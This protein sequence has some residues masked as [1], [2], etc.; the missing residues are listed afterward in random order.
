MILTDQVF[1]GIDPTSGHKSF[2]YAVL[3]RD[4]TLVAQAD[5][6]MEEV[7][8]LLSERKHAIV[9]VNAPSGVNLGLVREK[10][11]RELREPR[12]LRGVDLRLAEFELRELGVAVSGTPSRAELC[13]SW[14][15]LGFELYRELEKIGF[16]RYPA[17]EAGLQVLETQPHACYYSLTGQMPLPKP[18]LEGRLQRQLILHEHGVRVKDPMDFFEEITRYKLVKGILPLD[19]VYPAEMLDSLVAAYTAWVAMFRTENLTKIGDE[20]EGQIFLPDRLQK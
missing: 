2:V 14:M 18:T 12:V 13:P 3:D 8:A 17:G 9:A 15:Q 7:I 10:A 4:L 16:L 20:Q 19:M 11:R 5:G 1:F 6:E